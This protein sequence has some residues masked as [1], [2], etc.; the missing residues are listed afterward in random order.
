M[1]PTYYKSLKKGRIAPYSGYKWPQLNQWTEHI[2]KIEICESGYHAITKPHLIDWLEDEIHIVE[3]DGE[4][5]GG[6]GKVVGHRARLIHKFDTWNERTKRLFACD[7]A[8]R[9]LK[10]FEAQYP[11]D[12]RPRNAITVARRFANGKAT[13]EELAAATRGAWDAADS[14]ADSAARAAA[15]SA[16]WNAATSAWQAA[17]TSRLALLAEKKWQTKRLFEYLEGKRK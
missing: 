16:A 7:C 14:T 17:R 6:G 2:D 12:E 15:D 8:Q 4:V 11:K 5:D 3:F 1:K 13:K 9:T 10:I